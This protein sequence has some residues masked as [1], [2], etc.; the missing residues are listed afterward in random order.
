MKGTG[1]DKMTKLDLCALQ[2]P[3]D[4][5]LHAWV[6]KVTKCGIKFD[7]KSNKGL[8]PSSKESLSASIFARHED[9]SICSTEPKKPW[10]KYTSLTHTTANIECTAISVMF[11][12]YACLPKVYALQSPNQMLRDPMLSWR[13]P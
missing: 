11:S 13:C 1:T 4:R 10:A 8:G 5:V 2:C 12:E 6:K 3:S 9:K 7:R